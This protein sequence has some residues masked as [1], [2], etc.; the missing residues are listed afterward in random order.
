M[1]I[2]EAIAARHSVRAYT[3]ERI[4]EDIRKSLDEAA[5]EANREGSL[6]ISIRYDDPEGFD[7]KKFC[8]EGYIEWASLPEN[9]E[10]TISLK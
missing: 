7:S 6:N 10:Y 9:E 5:A 8:K 3:E 1:T 2:K 4:P